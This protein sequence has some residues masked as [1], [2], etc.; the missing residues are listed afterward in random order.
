MDQPGPDALTQD[1]ALKLGKH[2][3]QASHGAGRWA[4]L[5]SVLL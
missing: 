2:R 1:L 5:S 4:W 3:E